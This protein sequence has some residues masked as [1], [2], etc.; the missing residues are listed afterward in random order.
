MLVYSPM[1]VTIGAPELVAQVIVL[2]DLPAPEGVLHG[3]CAD[4]LGLI[5]L[6]EMHR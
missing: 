3:C 5:A 6:A 1:S 2:C 4:A